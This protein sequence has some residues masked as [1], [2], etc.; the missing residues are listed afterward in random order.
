MSDR[1]HQ[2]S[3]ATYNLPHTVHAQALKLLD[4]IAQAG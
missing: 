3:L 2:E 1:D 4:W